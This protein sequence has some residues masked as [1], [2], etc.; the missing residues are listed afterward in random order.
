MLTNHRL[1]SFRRYRRALPVLVIAAAIT[2]IALA[3]AV[4]GAAYASPSGNGANAGSWL[5]STPATWPLVVD[6]NS[7]PK[8]TLTHGVDQYSETLDTVSGREKGQV[9]DINLADPNV[10]LGTV[11]SGDTI[12]NPTNETVSSMANRT[13][14]VAGTNG[15]FFAIHATGSP[16]GMVVKGGELQ[17]SPVSS[18]PDDLVV[19][20]DG[21]VHIGTETFTGSVADTTQGSSQTIGDVNRLGIAADSNLSLVTPALGAASIGSSVVLSATLAAGSALNT[22]VLTVASVATGVTSLPA[23]TGKSVDLVASTGSAAATWLTGTVQSGDVLKASETLSAYPLQGQTTGKTPYVVTGLS[24]GAELLTNGQLGVPLTSTGG[25]N[26]LN[27]PVTGIGITKDGDH[28]IMAVF[29]GLAGE[30]TAEGLTRPQFAEWFAAH[31][32]YNAIMF[33]GGGSSEMVARAPGASTVSVLNTPSD[34]DERLVANGLFVYS[35]AKSAGP[36]TKVAINGGQ[37]VTTVPGAHIPVNVHALDSFDN[38]ASGTTQVQVVPGSLGSYQNGQLTVNRAG[39]GVII[40]RNGRVSTSEPLRVVSKLASLTISPTEPDLINGATEQFSLAGAAAGF[41]AVNAAAAQVPAGAAQW[42][43]TPADLGKVSADGLFTAD[44]TNGGLATVTATVGGKSASTTVAVGSVLQSV[45]PMDNA[46]TWSLHNTTGNTATFQTAAGVVPPGST[47]AGSLALT[48]SIAAKSGVKQL[49]LSKP[50]VTTTTDSDGLNP[51]GVGLWINGDDSGIDLAIEFIGADGTTATVYPTYVTWQ[52]WK[53]LSIPIPATLTAPVRIGFIDLLGI[54]PAT[55]EA[56]TINLSGLTALY[57]PR[58]VVAPTYTAVPDNPSWLNFEE[59]PASFTKTGATLLTG[60]DAHLIAADPGSAASNVMATIAQQ[61]PTLPAQAQPQAV[62]TLGDMADDGALVDLEYARSK[63]AAL[64]L[65]YRDL[66][67]NHEIT[68]GADPETGNF[69]QVFGDT[70]YAYTVGNSK[71]GVDMIITDSAHGGITESDS[72]Q[73]PSL[74]GGQW[75]WLVQQL[76]DTTS[77]NVVVATHEP[78]YDPHA[79][80]DSQFGDRWEAREYV[81]LIQRYTQTHPTKHVVMLYGHARGFAEQILDPDG[82]P[83]TVAAGGVPQLTFADF[84]MEAYAPSNQGGFYNY[85]LLHISASGDLQFVVQ[86]VLASIAVTAPTTDLVVGKTETLTAIGTNVG[87]D[88]LA[89]V[90]LPIA[91][92]ASHVWSSSNPK[93]ASVDANTG[94]VTAHKAGTV[95]LTVESDTVTASTTLTITK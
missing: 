56:G 61:L 53:F 69:S 70:H 5:P 4:A 75:P 58:P 35:T 16:E 76:T 51:T 30:S 94:V 43:V 26:N 91:D 55:A 10:R 44:V 18:W 63:I 66:V 22:P 38:P 60:D 73:T 31:G 92:P 21:T 11:E 90:T 7:T 34:G 85:G 17:E 87:G 40:A 28:A 8:A 84:G 64:G 68:Q 12:M 3:P 80:A 1:G 67:G 15:D 36:A 19:L 86:P 20:S 25:E 72:Y 52:G 24:G 93:V 46:S 39:D 74:A 9:V 48:Y 29:D 23:L 95:S 83:T 49:V 33:D 77:R 45:D 37:P 65:P 2:S 42:S 81:R 41:Q 50:G 27:E 88:N 32:A 82:N 57:S 79:V 62:Q 71:A 54:N 47:A 13:G 14:A 6:D 89:T 78:A 59:D